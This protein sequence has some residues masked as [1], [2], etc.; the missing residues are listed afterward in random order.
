LMV[1]EGSSIEDPVSGD[2]EF[3]GGIQDPVGGTEDNI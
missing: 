1:L 3:K 2:G